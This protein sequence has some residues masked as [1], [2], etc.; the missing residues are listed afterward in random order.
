MNYVGKIIRF[1]A[2][3]TLEIYLVG[4]VLCITSLAMFKKITS[5]ENLRSI[6]FDEIIPFRKFIIKDDT[7]ALL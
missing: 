4:F 1:I 6:A 3:L 5:A 2:A 7:S